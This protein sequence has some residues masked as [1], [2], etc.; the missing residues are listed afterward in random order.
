MKMHVCGR[1]L[2][3]QNGFAGNFMILGVF[4]YGGMMVN[5]ASLT[6]G[7]LSSFIMYSTYVGISIGG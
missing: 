1:A 7:G 6:V 5:D 2:F 4:Y 3:L